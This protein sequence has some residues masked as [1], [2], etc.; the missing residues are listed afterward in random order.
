MIRIFQIDAFTSKNFRGN[1][2]AVCPLE[3]WLDDRIL[4]EIAEENNLSETAFFVPELNYKKN[5]FAIRWFTPAAE[6]NLCGHP[7]IAAAYIIYNELNWKNS[8]INFSSRYGQL[9]TKK[10]DENIE[11]IFTKSQ[12]KKLPYNN[13]LAT[14]L[15][16]SY[17]E[18]YFAVEDYLAI[19]NNENEVRNLTP[20]FN[21]LKEFQMRGLV[22]SSL[23][24]DADFVSRAFFPRLNV[25]ENP[26]CSSAHSYLTI[27]WQQILGKICFILNKFLNELESYSAHHKAIKYFIRQ[28]QIIFAWRNFYL[29]NLKN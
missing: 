2:A 8:I 4:Q 27:Y 1:P 28:V 17:Q 14:A 23:G 5:N 18:L 22:A 26:V 29:E 25:N 16:A 9:T 24:E 7:T 21:L 6:V 15:G 3:Q 12:L 11:I 19:F 20:N 13:D 10:N